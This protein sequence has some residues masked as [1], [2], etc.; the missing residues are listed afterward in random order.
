MM[1]KKKEVKV[2]VD[3]IELEQKSLEENNY[4]RVILLMIVS[5]N[6]TV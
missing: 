6:E 1:N 2:Q 5:Y 3:K 4:L